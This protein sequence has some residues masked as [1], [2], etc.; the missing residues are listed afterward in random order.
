LVKEADAV[1]I[2]QDEMAIHRFPVLTRMW[3][4]VG[5]QPQVPTPGKNE[6]KVV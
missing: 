4:P 5:Q 3:A 1:L 2:F 6:N